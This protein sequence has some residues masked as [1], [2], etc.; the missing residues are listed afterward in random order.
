MNTQRFFGLIIILGLML[1][2][3]IGHRQVQ[4]AGD[5]CTNCTA[6]NGSLTAT[7]D[8]KYHPNG[9]Y[10]EAKT[11]GYHKGW[12]RGP[13]NTN[14]NL[15]LQ[16]WDGAKWVYVASSTNNGSEEAISF[17]GTP[18]FYT[19]QVYSFNGGGAYTLWLQFASTTPQPTPTPTPAANFTLTAT[20]TSVAAGGKVKVNFTAPGGRPEKDWIGLYKV[21]DPSTSYLT[22]GYTTGLPSG[23]FTFTMPNQAGQYEFRYFLENTYTQAARSNA[24][25][26]TSTGARTINRAPSLTRVLVSRVALSNG[27]TDTVRPTTAANPLGLSAVPG[28][29]NPATGAVGLL[30]VIAAQANPKRI[31]LDRDGN[32]LVDGTDTNPIALAAAGLPSCFTLAVAEGLSDPDGD[33]V[34]ARWQY[35]ASRFGSGNL[36]AAV[37]IPTANIT[38]GMELTTYDQLY[39]YTANSIIYEAPDYGVS[40]AAVT[41]TS[42]AVSL[43]AQAVDMPPGSLTPQLS[44]PQLAQVEYARSV[45]AEIKLVSICKLYDGRIRLRLQ[46]NLSKSF[47]PLNNTWF[48]WAYQSNNLT[49]V[50][51]VPAS[52]QVEFNLPKE[53]D[54]ASAYIWVA[55]SSKGP[56]AGANPNPFVQQPP[57]QS[58][59]NLTFVTVGSAVASKESISIRD[60]GCREICG[61]GL[62]NDGDGQIDEDCNYKLYVSDDKCKDDTIGVRVDGQDLGQTPTGQ[63]RFFDISQISSGEH[64]LIITA[65]A[66][67]GQMFGCS[68]D[69][70]VTYGLNLIGGAKILRKNGAAFEQTSD[71]GEIGVGTQVKY[72]IL[73][74]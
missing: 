73:I 27:R 55:A 8:S 26:V 54:G 74:P 52:T 38:A 37:S 48:R 40:P 53:Q 25:Q 31:S 42:G 17:Y 2:A 58:V 44:A 56:Q 69:A 46:A 4:A 14:F 21:G 22:W 7:N 33:P 64:T 36:Y 60:Q 3:A 68:P 47:D 13:A 71:S 67:A 5:P 29:G 32:G 20:L 59:G 72:T 66:S 15:Y 39:A 70:I 57:E 30:T 28:F 23:Y 11:A 12:L 9:S 61:D 63:G 18:G 41:S 16:R 10:Y 1:I 50:G 45:H 35:L 6:N 51:D 24:V 34:G 65:V 49:L 43:Q 19:W 62:D